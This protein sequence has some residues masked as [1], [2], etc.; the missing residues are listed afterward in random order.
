VPTMQPALAGSAVVAGDPERLINVIL[1]GPAAVLPPDREKFSNIMPPYGAAISDADVASVVSF[2][3]RNFA[4]GV[5]GEVTPAQVAAQ[6]A[7][8]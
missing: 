3:R 5:A 8:P 6:R 4:P 2:L 7:K 1:K